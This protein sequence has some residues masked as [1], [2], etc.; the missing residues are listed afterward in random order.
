MKIRKY[1]FN[2]CLHFARQD[3]QN[4]KNGKKI[5]QLK[6]PKYQKPKDENMGWTKHKVQ[7]YLVKLQRCDTRSMNT[8]S[9]LEDLEKLKLGFYKCQLSWFPLFC[10]TRSFQQD[11]KSRIHLQKIWSKFILILGVHSKATAALM[12]WEPKLGNFKLNSSSVAELDWPATSIQRCSPANNFQLPG[13]SS[14]SIFFDSKQFVM[15]SILRLQ[16]N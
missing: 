3:G 2:L 5:T 12:L 9:A 6:W 7:A 4:R 14:I 11:L 8:T 16:A 13:A 1:Y 15:D 10:C